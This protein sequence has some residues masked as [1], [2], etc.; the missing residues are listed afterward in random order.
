[1]T[2]GRRKTRRQVLTALGVLALVAGPALRAAEVVPVQVRD[3]WAEI[4][5]PTDH[6]NDK[7]FLILGSLAREAGPYS[8]TVRTEATTDAARFSPEPAAADHAWERRVTELAGRLER[9][10][11]ARPH[12]PWQRP[13]ADPPPEKV[14]HLFVKDDDFHNA[15]SYAAVPADLRRVG[16]HCQVY[17][18]RARPYDRRLQAA[19]ADTV[20]TFDNEVYPK[21]R[22][23]LGEALDVDRDGRFTIFFTSW[24]TRMQGG[25]VSLGGFVRGSDFYRDLEAPFGNRCDMMY[26]SADLQAGPFL[27]TVLAHEYTHAVVF[28]EHVF[29]NDRAVVAGQDEESWLNE[30]L[31]HLVEDRHGY[32]WANLDYRVSAFLSAPE[33]YR[34][35]V[36]DYYG[37]GVW[38]S[39]G[40]RGI[41]YLFLRWCADRYGE[42]LVTRLVQSNLRGVDN[43]EVATRARFADLFREWSAA[44]LLT[45]TGLDA[46]GALPLRRLNLRR[47]LGE[48]LLCGPRFT[49]V[50]LSGGRH[51]FELPG[52]GVTYL[53]LHTPA[54]PRSRITI[55]AA[56][57][58]ELQVSILR[59]PRA[60]PR[61]SVRWEAG[62]LH[63]TALG[64]GLTVDDIAWE[65]LTPAGR[66]EDTSFRSEAQAGKAVRE[67][68]GDAHLQAGQTR[69]CADLRLPR[70]AALCVIKVAATDDAGR[71][72]A[73]WALAAGPSP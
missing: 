59:L 73:G 9:A 44:L 67:L 35:V 63:L 52:T 57:D 33:S 34:L 27:R 38:R 58:A 60:Y 54:G 10:R 65:R 72:L 56:A 48:R 7:Y 16:R 2:A 26:L 70:D 6:P 71:R 64:G 17:V 55:T 14:F 8:V 28:S 50:K 62:R 20:R 42:Q 5:L 12:G 47:R 41:S 61:L 19:V 30:G 39:A 13:S 1:M 3:G 46:D 45:G 15:A 66:P 4:V 37:A 40:T 69:T 32:S 21:A 11:Q 22:R 53:L 36:A 43:L 51:T 68:V 18:E 31:A 49:E 29:D 23:Q 24:L 25:K